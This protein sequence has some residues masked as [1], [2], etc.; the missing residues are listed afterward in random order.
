[1]GVAIFDGHL[2]MKKPKIGKRWPTITPGRDPQVQIFHQGNLLKRSTVVIDIDDFEI[3][4]SHKEP[5]S[6]FKVIVAD[7]KMEVWLETVFV[8]GF[9]FALKDVD[10]TENL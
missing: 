9:E 4:I 5:Q 6:S 1:H 8:P 3:K 7:D 2:Y 10:Y